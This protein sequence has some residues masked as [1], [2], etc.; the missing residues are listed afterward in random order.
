MDNQNPNNTDPTQAMPGSNLS[1]PT[2][3][4][5][6]PTV[7]SD[8]P[9]DPMNQLGVQIPSTSSVSMPGFIPASDQPVL[10]QQ[11][12]MVIGGMSPHPMPS[13]MT[14]TNMGDTTQS[15]GSSNPMA[16]MPNTIGSTILGTPD[17]LDPAASISSEISAMPTSPLDSMMPSGMSSTSVT[18]GMPQSTEISNSMPAQ[19]TVNLPDGISDP[20]GSNSGT[21]IP[22]MGGMSSV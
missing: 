3:N 10:H 6:D 2:A 7:V 4:P 19:P 22:P 9:V 15:V 18:G 1:A 13:A 16:E 8:T 11:E 14:D 5:A 17:P 12:P 20:T 21:G